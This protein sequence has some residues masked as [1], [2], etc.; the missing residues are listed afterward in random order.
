MLAQFEVADGCI[1]KKEWENMTILVDNP[2]RVL[3]PDNGS[4][5]LMAGA[6]ILMGLFALATNFENLKIER[7]TASRRSG[8]AYAV[9][10]AMTTSSTPDIEKPSVP[11]NLHWIDRE[12]YSLYCG[13]TVTDLIAGS[14]KAYWDSATDNVGV[15]HYEYV[16][17]NP[18]DGLAWPSSG[19][20]YIVKN[21]MYSDKSY[22]PLA[23][24]YGFMVRAVD[25][26]GNKSNWADA[27]RTITGSCQ[28]TFNKSSVLADR[29]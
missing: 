8:V 21:S 22:T 12:S 6:L 7:V 13:S 18:P 1:K 11:T 5:L 2:M 29:Q 10:S 14:V 17:F 27:N 25:A 24:V 26:A 20:G 4:S 19:F 3:K 9:D 16:S 15:D 28:V 23:G